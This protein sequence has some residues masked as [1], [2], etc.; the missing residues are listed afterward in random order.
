MLTTCQCL[1][2]TASSRPIFR[3]FSVFDS[4]LDKSPRAPCGSFLAVC[5]VSLTSPNSLILVAHWRL[6]ANLYN[7]CLLV[8]TASVLFSCDLHANRFFLLSIC[9]LLL[10]GARCRCLQG[11]RLHFS[12]LGDS[13]SLLADCFSLLPSRYFHFTSRHLLLLPR[14]FLTCLSL[15]FAIFLFI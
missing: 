2:P 3:F 12:L 13:R 6:L 15:F 5:C 1:L 8:L 10:F 4:S 9:C 7:T 14:C 11:A